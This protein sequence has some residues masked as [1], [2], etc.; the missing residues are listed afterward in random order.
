M[1]HLAPEELAGTLLTAIRQVGRCA[2]VQRGWTDLRFE[3]LPKEVRLVDFVPHSWLFPRAACVVHAGGAGTTA[4][5]LRAGVPSV[6]IPHLLDQF[7][8]AALLQENGYSA[9][10]IPFH[11]LTADRLAASIKR[12]LLPEWGQ[13]VSR[14]S[15]QISGE[16][17]ASTA[18]ALIESHLAETGNS[19]HA[20]PQELL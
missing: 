1:V 8:W 20:P 17:G 15:E 7:V 9:D 2:I 13:R 14:V 6:V 3:S 4:A 19:L 12:A 18:A 10:T 16:N 5:T 11:E